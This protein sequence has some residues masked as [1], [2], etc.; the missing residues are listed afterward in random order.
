MEVEDIFSPFRADTPPRSN[1]PPPTATNLTATMSTP[2]TPQSTTAPQ[3]PA[4]PMLGGRLG[5]AAWIGG[6]PNEAFDGP[7]WSKI[8][9][10][11][12]TK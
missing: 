9:L 11:H 5:T 12:T 1:S 7:A 2:G 6:P 8:P 3:P 4:A 10:A